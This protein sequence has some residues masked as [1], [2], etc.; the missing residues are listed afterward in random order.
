MDQHEFS[1]HR[2]YVQAQR[3]V[4]LSKIKKPINRVFTSQKVVD[5]IYKHYQNRLAFVLSGM[6]HGVRKGQELDLFESVFPVAHWIGTEIVEELCDGERVVFADFSE[7][8]K[9]WQGAFDLIY[10]NSFDHARYPEETLNTWMG[11]LRS[12]GCLYIEWTRWHA[13]LGRRQ[14]RADC[15]A[16]ERDDYHAMFANVGRVDEIEIQEDRFK[17]VI[18]AVHK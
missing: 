2:K 8:R 12:G 18:F 14:N 16:A 11:Q 4:T 6:C 13:K 9:E 7:D 10:T 17:R 15:F 3:R 1:S 5:A